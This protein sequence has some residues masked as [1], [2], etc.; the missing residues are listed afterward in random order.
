MHS[1]PL[2][3]ERK[4]REWHTIQHIA[5]VKKKTHTYI[6][7]PHSH[8]QR[9]NNSVQTCSNE[10]NVKKRGVIFTYYSPQVQKITNL[11]RKTNLQITFCSTNTI[12]GM[13]R[14]MSTNTDDEHMKNGI[15]R[16]TCC[17]YKHIYV[18]QT[19]RNLRQRYLQHIRYIKNSDPKLSY[20]AHVLH[21]MHKYGDITSMSLIKQI[22]KGP[23]MNTYKQFHIQLYTYNN[24]LVTE[25]NQ[26]NVNR[27]SSS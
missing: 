4:Q 12:Y 25:C 26:E 16:L 1:L 27:C 9:R 6:R 3:H 8:I 13:F 22:K 20:A 7:S 2:S 19:G 15:Y 5:Q 18:G 23:S 14:P 21:N 11:F 17:T 10:S 24:K